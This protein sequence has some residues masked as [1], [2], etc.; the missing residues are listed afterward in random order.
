MTTRLR[1]QVEI[2][3]IQKMTMSDLLEILL[4]KEFIEKNNDNK[5]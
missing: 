4:S 5:N 3:G 2:K 1:A